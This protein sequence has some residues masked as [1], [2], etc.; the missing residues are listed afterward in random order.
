[1]V[2]P[3]FRD[4]KQ[5]RLNVLQ[6]IYFILVLVLFRNLELVFMFS[7]VFWVS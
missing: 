1:M 3:N 2:S 7:S 6:K 5:R 4:D